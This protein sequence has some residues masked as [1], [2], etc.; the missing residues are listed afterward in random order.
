ME[1]FENISK[2]MPYNVSEEYLDNLVSKVTEKAVE[3]GKEK[4]RSYAPYYW[5]VSLA[6]AAAILLFVFI[7][8]WGEKESREL[9]A[10]TGGVQVPTIRL[11]G[12]STTIVSLS[13][14]LAIIP[15]TLVKVVRYT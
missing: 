5:A 13:M 12:V 2:Q 8:N 10:P 6:A 9:M 4:K 14:Q 3:S 1:K 7:R 15:I 11:T